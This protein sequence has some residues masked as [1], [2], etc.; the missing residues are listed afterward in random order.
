MA[1]VERCGTSDQRHAMRTASCGHRTL[2]SCLIAC[3]ML[4]SV[5][6]GAGRH[7]RRAG[8]HARSSAASTYLKRQQNQRRHLDRPPGLSRRRDRA[9]H[10]GTAQCG[11]A[12]DDDPQLQAS[13]SYLRHV[14]PHDRPTPC[15]CRPWCSAPP[16]RRKICCSS[17]ATCNGW[18]TTR[19]TDGETDAAPGRYPRPAS[20][21]R[22]QLE[23]PVRP[24]GSVRGRTGRRDGQR[25][26]PGGMRCEYWQ[27]TQNPD[28]SW[29]Y[30]P[31]GG[32]HRQ[33]DLRRHRRR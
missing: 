6:A 18:K 20:A 9:L 29:G 8:S 26:R 2:R 19:F 1:H 32:R 33:H 7:R 12:P 31:T 14:Q 25:R 11:R 22:R 4:R 27:Q 17:A 24:A 15:R 13:L 28:G 23:H 30:R 21:T 5:P 10:A 3:V 16:S